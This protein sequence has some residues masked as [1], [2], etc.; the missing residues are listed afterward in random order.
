MYDKVTIYFMSGTGNSYRVA[1]WI[2]QQD[3]AAGAQSQV[4]PIENAHPA[5]EVP[6]A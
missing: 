5:D 2:D 6:E 3:R 1:T 4:I